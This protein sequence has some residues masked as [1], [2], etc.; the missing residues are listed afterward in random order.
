MKWVNTTTVGHCTGH[1][2]VWP[3]AEHVQTVENSTTSSRLCRSADRDVTQDSQKDKKRA[4]NEAYQSSDES[5]K[6]SDE[7]I[8]KA[9][10]RVTVKSFNFNSINSL[11]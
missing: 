1:D 6:G 11:L 9:I 3:M 2:N 7:E 4:V 10:D 8:N 5:W